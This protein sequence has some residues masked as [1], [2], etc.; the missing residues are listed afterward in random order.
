MVPALQIPKFVDWGWKFN[1]SGI[2]F[3]EWTN[4]APLSMALQELIKCECS[5]GLGCN[6]RCKCNSAGLACTELCKCNGDCE[7]PHN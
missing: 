5:V 4:M 7:Q 6:K 1:E 2:V 3:P